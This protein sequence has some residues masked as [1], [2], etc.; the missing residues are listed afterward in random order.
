MNAVCFQLNYQGWCW[1]SM[2]P[3]WWRSSLK[4][5]TFS[6]KQPFSSE[7]RIN[8]SLSALLISHTY[9]MLMQ[10]PDWN[11]LLATL[12]EVAATAGAVMKG[13]ETPNKPKHKEVNTKRQISFLIILLLASMSPWDFHQAVGNKWEWEISVRQKV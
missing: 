3:V 5:H 12:C 10:Q 8:A 13:E 11:T 7:H 2:T 9:N 4:K 1:L 6:L